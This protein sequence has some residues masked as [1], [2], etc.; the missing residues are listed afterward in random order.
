MSEIIDKLSSYNLFNYLFPGALFVAL[1][2]Q[3]S[4]RNFAQDDILVA[5][6]TY[7]FIGLVISRIG[8]LLLEPFL[9]KIGFLNFANYNSFLS[10]LEKDKKIDEISEANNMYRTLCSLFI[11][12]LGLVAIDSIVAVFPEIESFVSPV[13]IIILFI[14]FLFS[15]RKQTNYINKRVKASEQ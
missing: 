2:S 9:K 8:S 13:S 7:Y 3:V 1:S 10:A 4:T 6:F 14:L 11:C 15:Y 5:L 12:L